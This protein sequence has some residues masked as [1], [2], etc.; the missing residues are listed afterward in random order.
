MA[1]LPMMNQVG[2]VGIFR[3]GRIWPLMAVATAF[4]SLCF[5]GCKEVF[6]CGWDTS[7][8]AASHVKNGY[9][10]GVVRDPRSGQ[11]VSNR[12]LGIH[13]ESNPDRAIT[14]TT[15]ASGRY[16]IVWAHERLYPD[17]GF[18][19]KFDEYSHDAWRPLRGLPPP[20]GCQTSSA[21]VSWNRADDLCSA[22]QWKLLV[23]APL[24]AFALLL[25]GWVFQRQSISKTLDA[26]GA[27]ATITSVILNFTLW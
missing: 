26:A 14:I 17:V 7:Y 19:P 18:G 6:A 10:A 9:Y 3:P 24:L 15:D 8:C 23:A 13:F 2:S 25:C 22:W 11:P 12:R 21:S 1:Q 16:C 27:A 4:V 20:P 5:S